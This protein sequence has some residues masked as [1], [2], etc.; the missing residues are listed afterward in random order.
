LTTNTPHAR[1]V[2][3]LSFRNLGDEKNIYLAEAMT[4]ELVQH[5]AKAPGLRVASRASFRKGEVAGEDLRTLGKR[6]GV[7]AIVEGTIQARSDGSMH[8]AVRLVEVDRGFPLFS[9]QIERKAH[10]VFSV[11]TEL[12][13]DI[14]R[15]LTIDLGG[16]PARA[17]A[18]P[19][20]VDLFLRARREYATQTLAGVSEAYRLLKGIPAGQRDPLLASWMALARLRWW[21]FAPELGPS[22]PKEAQ[23]LAESLSLEDPTLGEAH[24]ALAVLH[25]L[26]GHTG[27]AIQAATEAV[28]C[29][30]TLGEANLLLGTLHVETGSIEEGIRRLKL[31]LRLD[32]RNFLSLLELARTAELTGDHD[33]ADAWL[34]LADQRAPGHVQPALLR[35]RIASWRGEKKG[36]AAARAQALAAS[37]KALP[38]EADALHLFALDEG[39]IQVGRL[40]VSAAIG[41]ASA[42]YRWTLMQLVAEE[43][44]LKKDFHGA[45]S[46]IR[47][48][49][50]AGFVDI[51]WL[52]KCAAFEKLRTDAAFEAVRH[53]IAQRA[54]T[55]FA[56]PS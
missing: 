36:L 48:A 19:G 10:E 1:G 31:A 15:A 47:S 12:A 39:E 16:A 23:L 41:G 5:L 45:V 2:A 28:R 25:D 29:N 26:Q 17:P 34:S 52:E 9:T 11:S 51:L 27:A 40:M 56:R 3:V 24:L 43:R 22:A 7:N 6:L 35:V 54:R 30:P 32:P 37:K 8:I 44:A 42:R 18:A 14:A 21:G 46:A 49:Q 4:D 38:T 55:A 20:V 33:G 50:G 53:T 13:K